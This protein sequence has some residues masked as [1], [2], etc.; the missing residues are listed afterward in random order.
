[1]SE[2]ERGT[3]ERGTRS[4]KEINEGKEE[5]RNDGSDINR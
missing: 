5:K 4:Q 3:A 1:M 2:E